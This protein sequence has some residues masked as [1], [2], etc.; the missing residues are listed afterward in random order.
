M[1]IIKLI[2]I[3][4][5]LIAAASVFSYSVKKDAS[6]T[7]QPIPPQEVAQWK[8]MLEKDS[9]IIYFIADKQSMVKQ[10]IP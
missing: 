1:K 7:N 10:L 6:Y 8:H 4:T 2:T 5:I 3:G 9:K